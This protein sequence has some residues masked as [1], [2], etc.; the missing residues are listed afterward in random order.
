MRGKIGDKERLGHILDAIAEIEAYTAN[1]NLKNFLANSMMRFASIK[2]IE[3]IGEAANYITPETKMLF[4]DIEW[5]QIVGMRH[6]LIHE[7]FG[8]DENLVWQVIT[9]DI[10]KLKIAVENISEQ[11]SQQS[12]QSPPPIL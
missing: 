6:I 2:Q 1:I 4:T 7:Y 3:I 11:I 8:V 9:N 12:G 5:K 10:P